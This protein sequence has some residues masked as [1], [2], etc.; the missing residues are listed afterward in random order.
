MVKIMV[1][2]KALYTTIILIL[3]FAME[4][5][6]KFDMNEGSKII[7][8]WLLFIIVVLFIVILIGEF[9]EPTKKKKK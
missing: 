7:L 8:L 6:S 4:I 5:I 2:L 3:V 1:K 9:L